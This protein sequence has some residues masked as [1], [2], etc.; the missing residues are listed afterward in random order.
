M[1]L[2][3]DIR[4]IQKLEAK[5]TQTECIIESHFGGNSGLSLT[6]GISACYG[7]SL[8]CCAVDLMT[9]A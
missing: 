3:S 8:L 4:R 1:E 7:L 9:G 2:N 6:T 5:Q